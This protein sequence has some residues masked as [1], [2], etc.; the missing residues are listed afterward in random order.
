MAL[1]ARFIHYGNDKAQH[2]LL[3]YFKRFTFHVRCTSIASPSFPQHSV[4]GS[5]SPLFG[6][7]GT[8]QGR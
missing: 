8:S 6:A 1:F 2:L 5:A 7:Q 4:A 3:L